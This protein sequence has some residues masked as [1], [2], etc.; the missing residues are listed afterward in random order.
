MPST[1][2]SFYILACHGIP[3]TKI[4]RMSVTRCVITIDMLTF[5]PS[6][7]YVVRNFVFLYPW[8]GPP[9]TEF[10]KIVY[11]TTCH[12]NYVTHLLYLLSF[13]VYFHTH[14]TLSTLDTECLCRN[15]YYL[16]LYY[17][18]AAPKIL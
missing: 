16:P 3:P 5:T 2:L 11:N 6:T 8:H 4:Y 15:L 10:R 13:F 1:T 14:S 12:Y 18:L 9:Q 7:W 17:R